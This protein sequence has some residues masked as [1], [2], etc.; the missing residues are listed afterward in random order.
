MVLHMRSISPDMYDYRCFIS[1]LIL[2]RTFYNAIRTSLIGV[3]TRYTLPIAV[4]MHSMQHDLI[5][6]IE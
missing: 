5:S 6:L 4:P 2:R 3:L 1:T